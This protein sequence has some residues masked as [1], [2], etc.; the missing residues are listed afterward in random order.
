MVKCQKS[1][2]IVLLAMLAGCTWTGKVFEFPASEFSQPQPKVAC[3]TLKSEVES[4]DCGSSEDKTIGESA[5]EILSKKTQLNSKQISSFLRSEEENNETGGK[6]ILPT[7]IP[8]GYKIE[9]V[10]L[11][12]CTQPSEVKQRHSYRIV[13]RKSE[14][15]SFTVSNYLV[16][17][18]G[19]ADP[20]DFKTIDMP[21]AKFG[22]LRISYKEFDSLTNTPLIEGEISTPADNSGISR[23]L[24]LLVYENPS[25]N[26]E[27]VKK[28]MS[29]M[30]Y[31]NEKN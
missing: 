29:S 11:N 27:E 22:I 21:S 4:K 13:Y 28:I 17:G 5:L 1:C 25:L 6:T 7:Y 12:P 18:Q 16:C 19:G 20:S 2:L 10:L 26:I 24:M 23:L 9:S 3:S 30:D 14:S 15:M 31:L 8:E